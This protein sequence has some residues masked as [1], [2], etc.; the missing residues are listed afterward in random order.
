[1]KRGEIWAIAGGADY[2]GKPRPAIA[3][4]SDAFDATLSVTIC[5][6]T[7]SAVD[8]VYARLALAPSEKNGLNVTSYAMIDKITTI[9]RSK[10]GQHIGS[11]DATELSALNQRVVLFLGLAE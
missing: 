2:A 11:L 10:V 9:S 5:P 8:A 4:Q 3:L 1:M 6:L 7:S